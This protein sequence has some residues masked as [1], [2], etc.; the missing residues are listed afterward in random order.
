M[1]YYVAFTFV[2]HFDRKRFSVEAINADN[3]A[4]LKAVCDNRVTASAQSGQLYWK[5]MST[6][7]VRSWAFMQSLKRLGIQDRYNC[8]DMASIDEVFSAVE[9]CAQRMA[10]VEKLR[11]FKEHCAQL[12]NCPAETKSILERIRLFNEL[13]TAVNH[14]TNAAKIG[15][16]TRSMIKTLDNI[17]DLEKIHSQTVA[18]I[19]SDR[20]GS[21]TKV[22]A[23][24]RQELINAV[25]AR[26]KDPV[27]AWENFFG[28]FITEETYERCKKGGSLYPA[29]GYGDVHFFEEVLDAKCIH[30]KND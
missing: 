22:D 5:Q 17:E 13:I 20:M 29:E 1:T 19:A 14:E 30:S 9:I 4:E 26:V 15:S 2:D 23:T 28:F 16:I 3:A 7:E 25:E 21:I 6:T 24:T 27:N 18:V 12:L 8:K 10:E 11:M